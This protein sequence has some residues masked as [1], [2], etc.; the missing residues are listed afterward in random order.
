MLPRACMTN[1]DLARLVNSDEIQSVVRPAEEDVQR[2]KAPKKNP[3]K[4]LEA[5]LALNPY[6]AV[7]RETELKAAKARA[8]SKKT[9][10][11]PKA[12]KARKAA[13]KAFYEVANVEGEVTI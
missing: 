2:P 1:A 7:H 3:L 5:M 12:V 4:N 10:K 6:H 11:R 8:S 9:A 13:S